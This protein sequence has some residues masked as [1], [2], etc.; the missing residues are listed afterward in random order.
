MHLVRQLR[1][2]LAYPEVGMVFGLRLHTSWRLS[3]VVVRHAGSGGGAIVRHVFW[4]RLSGE[5]EALLDR[6]PKGSVHP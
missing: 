1:W 5:A 2:R 4:E 3:P 6:S